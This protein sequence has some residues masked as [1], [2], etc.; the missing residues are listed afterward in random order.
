[1]I[2]LENFSAENRDRHIGN[3]LYRIC[4]TDTRNG[5]GKWYIHE[6]Y[7]DGS[8]WSSASDDFVS[9]NLRLVIERIN[10]FTK[11]MEIVSVSFGE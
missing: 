9:D 6:F 1:M 2:T 10:G 4:N 5:S 7:N 8:T 11:E 3:S